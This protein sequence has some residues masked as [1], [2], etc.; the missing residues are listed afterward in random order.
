MPV[1]FWTGGPF[2][3]THERLAQ[4]QLVKS[5]PIH[6][7]GKTEPIVAAFNFTID[8]AE[9]DLLILKR[10]SIIIIDFKECGGPVHATKNGEWRF[11]DGGSTNGNPY[12]QIRE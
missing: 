10:D 5:L 11:R 12:R 4:E 3:K 6:I 9:I 7:A 2:E 8:G 1:E